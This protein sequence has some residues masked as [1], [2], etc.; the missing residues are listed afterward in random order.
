MVNPSFEQAVLFMSGVLVLM[1][2]LHIISGHRLYT[3][4]QRSS[5]SLL[6]HLYLL[7]VVCVSIIGTASF[8]WILTEGI[9]TIWITVFLAAVPLPIYAVQWKLQR[10]MGYTGWFGTA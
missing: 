5:A 9:P 6:Y 3:E 1:A 4:E 7:G 8:V 10:E 2:P